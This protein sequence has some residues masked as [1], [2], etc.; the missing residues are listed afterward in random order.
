M[1]EN[2]PVKQVFLVQSRQFYWFGYPT[3]QS[4]ID[5]IYGEP[6]MIIDNTKIGDLPDWLTGVE[7]DEVMEFG[8]RRP[9][10]FVVLDEDALN[11]FEQHGFGIW[12]W[13]TESVRLAKE[14]AARF[15]GANQDQFRGP[16]RV[17]QLR[18]DQF[19][20]C[21]ADSVV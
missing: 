8:E 5:S 14:K 11:L 16:L 7:C 20:G 21:L 15:V 2:T 13:R 10:R 4:D 12:L 3:F 17:V 19:Q 18:T 6:A 9:I 1:T